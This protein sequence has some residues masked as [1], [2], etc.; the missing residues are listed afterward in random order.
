VPQ[1]PRHDAERLRRPGVAYLL[2]V[3][4]TASSR[5]WQERMQAMGLDPREVV[6]LRMVA[7]DPGRSQRSLGPA[8]QVRTSHL[9]A[10]IDALETRGLLERRANPSDRRANAL[11]LTPHGHAALAEVMQV[12]VEHENELTEGLSSTERTALES[13]LARMA[14]RQGLAEGGH[15]G[16]DS[17]PE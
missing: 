15:P 1:A 3:V 14:S 10:V 8:L 12:S 6:V 13:V 2:S 4:G 5:R 11:H 17:E 9:V 16:F 7:A